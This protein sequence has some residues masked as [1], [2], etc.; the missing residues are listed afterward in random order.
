MRR[1]MILV[2]KRNSRRAGRMDQVRVITSSLRPLAPESKSKARQK[3]IADYIDPLDVF[4][5]VPSVG[6]LGLE[7]DAGQ[8]VIMDKR[9]IF[10]EMSVGDRRIVDDHRAKLLHHGQGFGGVNRIGIGYPQAVRRRG[11]GRGMTQL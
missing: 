7:L 11:V 2:S 6:H 9:S 5:V 1:R 3:N 4:I 8:V 10:P